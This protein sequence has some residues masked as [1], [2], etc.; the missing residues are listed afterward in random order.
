MLKIRTSTIYSRKTCGTFHEVLS[1]CLKFTPY[2][3]R[4]KKQFLPCALIVT[5]F[6][7]R[8][9]CS[10]ARHRVRGSCNRNGGKCCTAFYYAWFF[11]R[12]YGCIDRNKWAANCFGI[13][14][15]GLRWHIHKKVHDYLFDR[16]RFCLLR[17][18][19]F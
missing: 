14:E 18:H 16:D 10:T 3:Q 17:A 13:G 15:S 9:L 7:L 19:I 11:K 1:S 12:L 6:P 4:W 2:L 8:L 5:C